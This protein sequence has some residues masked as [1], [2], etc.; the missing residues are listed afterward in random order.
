M[1]IL[2]LETINSM[3]AFTM[4][5]APSQSGGEQSIWLVGIDYLSK[6]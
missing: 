1:K 3:K 2:P 6:K 4:G 5:E